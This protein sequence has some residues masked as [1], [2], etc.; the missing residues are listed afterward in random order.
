MSDEERALEQEIMADA[1]RRAERIKG[2]ADRD[3]DQIRDRADAEAER[4]RER[5]M[6][7]ARARA[8][9]ESHRAEARIELARESVRL[10]AL[11]DILTELEDRAR[12][13][14]AR[15][16]Q[17]DHYGDV[18]RQLALAAIEA[19]TGDRFTLALRDED[20]QK[21]GDELAEELPRVARERLDREVEVDFAEEN[22]DGRGGLT[23]RSADGRQVADQRFDARLER[24]WDELR[25]ELMGRLPVGIDRSREGQ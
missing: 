23:V 7:Q 14:L 8:E 6:R 18:L 12:T 3:A 15:L 20:R 1:R 24:M 19:M 22:P 13:E 9:K 5:I 17:S 25:Q 4:R 2:R 21:W 11:Q 16:P 10:R